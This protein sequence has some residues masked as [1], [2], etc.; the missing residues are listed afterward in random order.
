MECRNFTPAN[1]VDHEQ[2]T[3]PTSLQSRPKY[4]LQETEL[5]ELCLSRF[6]LPQCVGPLAYN[7]SRRRM[8]PQVPWTS[9]CSISSKSSLSIHSNISMAPAR[10]VDNL[11]Q[12]VK[13]Y[14][15]QPAP[16]HPFEPSFHCNGKLF[17]STVRQKLSKYEHL[18]QKSVISCHTYPTVLPSSSKGRRVRQI[19]SLILFTQNCTK[20]F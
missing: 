17:A 5:D 12:M 10:P 16:S 9:S 13:T 8:H 4:I 3:L 18:S 19:V 2:A 11:V 14:L 7:S 20:L 6:K 1:K 15:L